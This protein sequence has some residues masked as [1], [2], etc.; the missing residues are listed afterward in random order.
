MLRS[1]GILTTTQK[2]ILL[3]F[4]QLNDSSYFNLT[5]GTALSEFYF[6]HRRSFDLDLFTS[7]KDLILP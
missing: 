7:E 1:K 2:R 3:A 4:S 5:G 6:G